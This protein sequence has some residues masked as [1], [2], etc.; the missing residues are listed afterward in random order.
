MLEEL[1]QSKLEMLYSWIDVVPLSRPK[2]S[3]T[4]DFSDGV[5]VAELVQHFLPK[6]V[7][8]HNYSPANSSGQK[9]NNWGVLQRRVFAKL[10]FAIP[11]PV[12]RSVCNC[13]PGVVEVVLLQLKAKI[14]EEIIARRENGSPTLSEESEVEHNGKVSVKVQVG[15]SDS[16]SLQALMKSAFGETVNLNQTVPRILYEE[17][18]QG[19]DGRRL[20]SLPFLPFLNIT[21]SLA[22]D[23]TIQIMN[24]KLRRM[25]HLIALKEGRI[26]LTDATKETLQRNT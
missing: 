3:L 13:K 2:K 14:E 16:S 1:D 19:T 6:L 26:K 17:K 5:L 18:E 9:L 24:A 23:E 7:D 25:E 22:K 21:E 15:G 11:E 8:M 4:R 12:V 20:Q 10:K